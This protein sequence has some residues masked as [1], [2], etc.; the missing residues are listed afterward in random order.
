MSVSESIRVLIVD[1]HGIL[2]S[3]LKTTLSIFKDIEVVGEAEDGE[4]AVRLCD[5]L[6][7]AVVLMDLV[8]PV[9]DGLTCL[10]E[11][12]KRGFHQRVIVLTALCDPQQKELIL[13]AGADQYLLKT[14]LLGGLPDLVAQQ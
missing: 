1:D 8:M 13:E 12:R 3:G 4:E 10:R 11:L 2:R 6:H 5:E 7:P 14:A 9:M